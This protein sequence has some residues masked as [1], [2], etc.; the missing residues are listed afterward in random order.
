MKGMKEPEAM[1]RDNLERRPAGELVEIILKQ[2]EMIQRL[3]EEVERLRQIINGDSRTSSKPPSGDLIK[4]SE[5]EKPVEPEKEGEEKRRK[6]GGQ[7]GHEG[8]TRKGFGRVD[9]TEFLIPGRCGV[10]GSG[11]FEGEVLGIRSQEV[12]QLAEHPIEIVRYERAICKCRRCGS[13]EVAE[14]PATVVEGQDLGVSLQGMLVWLSHYGH[15]SYEKQE[16]WLWELGRIRVG[17]G[18]LQATTRRVAAA[19]KPSVD[20]LQEWIQQ[21][22]HVQVDESPWLVKGVKEWIWVATGVGFCFFYAADTRS[23]AELETILGKSFAGVLSSDDFSVYN[24]YEVTNQQKCLAHLRRHFKRVMKLK[25]SSQAKLGEAF[26]TLLDESF[27]QHAAWKVSQDTEAYNQWASGFK[28][29]VA[30]AIKIWG[31]EAG[32]AAMLLLKSLRKKAHQW[33][34]FLDHPEVPPDNNQAERSIRLAVTKRKICGGSRSMKGFTD[35]AVLLSV[36]QTCRAQGRS[37]IS[38]LISAISRSSSSFSLI[39]SP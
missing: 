13:R 15:L 18:T 37:I 24:G 10:C 29:R 39:P 2:Q 5:K 17:V 35:T 36:V 27:K 34:Y 33:W 6:A 31:K 8:R 21:Q 26:I 28:E 30:E 38:F 3:F 23:R 11:E 19:V 12:A 9:R 7:P 20:D 25:P 22:E 14:L 16:E 1:G 32:H 4:R